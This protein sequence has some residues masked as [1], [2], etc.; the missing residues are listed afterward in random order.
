MELN[1]FEEKL[2]DP[3]VELDEED[4][5]DLLVD[6]LVLMDRLLQRQNNPQWLLTSAKDLQT[7][8]SESLSWYHIH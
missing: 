4:V 2:E 8:L 3:L 1:R 5:Q 6:C 7:R